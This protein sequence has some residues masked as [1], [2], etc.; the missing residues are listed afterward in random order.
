VDNKRWRVSQQSQTW[1]RHHLIQKKLRNHKKLLP[2]IIK[3][4]PLIMKLL[5][6]K[7]LIH[8]H[9]FL[10]ENL[11]K[12]RRQSYRQ[13]QHPC[14]KK[15][16]NQQTKNSITKWERSKM[17][18]V[19]WKFLI[20]TNWHHIPKNR[21]LQICMERIGYHHQFNLVHH[22]FH[23][24]SHHPMSCQEDQQIQQP[25]PPTWDRWQLHQKNQHL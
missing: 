22:H 17:C 10:L 15:L 16:Q 25:W 11:R 12:R 1:W 6:I 23:R 14:K 21:Y 24:I 8:L 18:I 9:Q 19:V 4:L 2:L 7:K 5:Q 3:L 13:R 20:K